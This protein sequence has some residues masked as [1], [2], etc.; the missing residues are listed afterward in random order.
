VRLRPSLVLYSAVYVAGCAA[1]PKTTGVAVARAEVVPRGFWS[2]GEVRASCR[3]T[4]RWKELREVPARS[5]FCARDVLDRALEEQARERGATLLAARRCTE[6]EAGTLVCTAV[7]ARACTAHA[8]APSE[9]APVVAVDSDQLS[10]ELAGRVAIDLE[11][12][13]AAFARRARSGA[14]VHESALLPV[15]QIELGVM[16]ARCKAKTCDADETRA[17]LRAAAGGLGVPELVGVRC[18]TYQEEMSCVA[19]LAASERDPETDP[20]A[21]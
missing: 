8:S 11:P 6:D 9:P 20:S 7:A 14:D 18:F 16:R 21:R 12:S 1:T 10:A 4:E 17:A 13:V 3:P 2:V 15:G 19:T 5:L